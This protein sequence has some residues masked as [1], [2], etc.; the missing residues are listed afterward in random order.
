LIIKTKSEVITAHESD[1]LN[2][3]SASVTVAK[4]GS[5]IAK[6]DFNSNATFN[7]KGKQ[8]LDL[9]IRERGSYSS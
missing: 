8:V 5:P 7:S 3:E 6:N 2:S 4:N 1:K 9:Q